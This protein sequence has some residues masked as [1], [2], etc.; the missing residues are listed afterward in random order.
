MT[1]KTIKEAYIAL[2]SFSGSIA[3]AAKVTG[4]AKCMFLNNELCIARS[5][6]I[7]SNLEELHYDSQIVS[8]NR[9]KGICN[10]FDNLSSTIC[11]LNKREYLSLNVFHLIKEINDSK[12]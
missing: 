12:N 8:L 11:I 3:R 9:C 1:L 5:K 7:D 6:L 10:I 4:Y 2:L